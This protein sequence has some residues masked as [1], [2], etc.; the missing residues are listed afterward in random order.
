M[1]GELPYLPISQPPQ[2]ETMDTK[3]TYRW[4]MVIR[5]RQMHRLSACV[6]ACRQE[7]NISFA[8]EKEANWKSEVLDE[9][10][11]E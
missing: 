1:D 4:G 9:P 3:S 5:F 7:N 8:G 10:V 11:S 6:V 2:Y